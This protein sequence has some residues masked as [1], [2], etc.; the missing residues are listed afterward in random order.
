VTKDDELV[1]EKTRRQV[2]NAVCCGRLKSRQI[3]VIRIV[4][5]DSIIDYLNRSWFTKGN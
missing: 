2:D 1:A 3:K 5:G 4:G